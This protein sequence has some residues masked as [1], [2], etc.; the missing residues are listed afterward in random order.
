VPTGGRSGALGCSEQL[1]G[2]GRA[3]QE[4]PVILECLHY[5]FVCYLL[6]VLVF[7]S[8]FLC[9]ALAVLELTL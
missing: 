4:P 5:C 2:L 9:I 3:I 1:E 7:E 6:F 8:G